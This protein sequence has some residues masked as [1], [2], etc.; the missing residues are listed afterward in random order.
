MDLLVRALHADLRGSKAGTEK[1]LGSR[2]V[3]ERSVGHQIHLKAEPAS[4]AY[5]FLQVGSQKRL[6]AREREEGN[7]RVIPKDL[8]NALH[9]AEAH[10][11]AV[12]P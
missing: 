12:S 9:V 8:E 1:A 11:H 4:M 7:P 3:R 6:S 2:M 5:H 10:L